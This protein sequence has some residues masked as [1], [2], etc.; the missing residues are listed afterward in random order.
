MT[1]IKV[2]RHKQHHSAYAL[3]IEFG[4]V[5]GLFDEATNLMLGTESKHCRL[6]GR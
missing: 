5:L 3:Y 2:S 6:H 4:D 1:Y